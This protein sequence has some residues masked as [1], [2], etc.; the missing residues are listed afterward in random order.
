[1]HVYMDTHA[2]TRICTHMFKQIK[3]EKKIVNTYKFLRRLNVFT[4][5]EID[6]KPI[7]MI[8]KLMVIPTW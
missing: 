5:Q 8:D 4:S 2:Y 1:M 6:I 7:Y 3:I